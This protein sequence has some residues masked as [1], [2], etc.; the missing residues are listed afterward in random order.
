[1]LYA[2]GSNGSGQ[3]GIGHLE[4]VPTPTPISGG[5]ERHPL[6]GSSKGIDRIVAGGNHTLVLDK[7]GI[8]SATGEK[9]DGRCGLVCNESSAQLRPLMVDVDPVQQSGRPLG[10][11]HLAATW[12]ASVFVEVGGEIVSVCG[13]GESGELGLGTGV[14]VAKE[15]MAIEGFP[16]TGT[17]VVLVAACMAHVVAVLSNGE[18]W[19]WGKGRKGQL[20]EPCIDV[21]QPRKIEG[22]PFQAVTAVCGKDFTCVLGAPSS[23]EI[24]L[25][26][27]KGND[28]FGVRANALSA[29]PDWKSITA[30]W[31]S[32]FVL[33]ETGKILAW[34]RNDHGQLPSRSLPKI[35]KL[36]AGSEHCIALSSDGRVL[37]W[38]WG[39]HGNCGQPTHGQGDVKSGY[40]QLPVDGEVDNVFAGCATSFISTVDDHDTD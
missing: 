17:K 3:L 31:G 5:S 37:A 11:E 13:T 16:P 8:V 39:E 40:N 12:A 23:G 24:L 21:W 32:V 30:S 7:D 4:D 28:R 6:L 20:G 29:V 34:G 18:V 26:G 19:G 25:L 27:P 14:K 10:I 38:G 9:T 33:M 1:M 15:R 35:A 22:V 36:A 2:L